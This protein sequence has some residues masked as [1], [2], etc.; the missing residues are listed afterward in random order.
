MGPLSQDDEGLSLVTNSF[1]DLGK[2]LSLP[3]LLLTI[4]AMSGL[5]RK[6]FVELCWLGPKISQ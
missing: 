3:G 5:A 4:S 2:F 1:C 6:G